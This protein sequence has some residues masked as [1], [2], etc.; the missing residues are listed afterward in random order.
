MC[1]QFVQN[2]GLKYR[3]EDTEDVVDTLIEENVVYH[4]MTGTDATLQ[5][6]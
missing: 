4:S 6:L 1:R 5:L 2:Y 3:N